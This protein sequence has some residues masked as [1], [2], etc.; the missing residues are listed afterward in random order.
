MAIQNIIQMTKLSDLK[1]II[2]VCKSHSLFSIFLKLDLIQRCRP[3]EE[4][5]HGYMEY[6]TVP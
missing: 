2:E 1:R 4:T 6:N 3:S 5:N